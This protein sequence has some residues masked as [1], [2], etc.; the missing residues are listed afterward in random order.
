MEKREREAQDEDERAARGLGE[1]GVVRVPKSGLV[2]S[3]SG[4]S[5]GRSGT[6]ARDLAL[7]PK[8]CL[9]IGSS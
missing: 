3:P 1:G 2:Q 8:G 6:R 4:L 5:R 9:L 7:E